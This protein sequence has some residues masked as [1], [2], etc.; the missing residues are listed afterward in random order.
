MTS[1][2]AVSVVRVQ[3][4]FRQK[5]CLLPKLQKGISLV[6]VCTA[7]TLAWLSYSRAQV[8]RLTLQLVQGYHECNAHQQKKKTKWLN[9][10]TI[11]TRLLMLLLIWFRDQVKG[12]MSLHPTTMILW[13]QCTVGHMSMDAHHTATSAM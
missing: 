10:R 5:F 1:H 3:V 9:S 12:D 11:V 8:H 4:R 2:N 13:H 6:I 7:S